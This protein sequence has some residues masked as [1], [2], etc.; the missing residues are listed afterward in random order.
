MTILNV[1]NKFLVP[2]V[3]QEHDHPS[4]PTRNSPT[5]CLC[6]ATLPDRDRQGVDEG[7]ASQQTSRCTA[8]A[9]REAPRFHH[10]PPAI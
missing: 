1:S 7:G 6:S 3:T 4:P 10:E 5:P 9:V 8:G 2:T